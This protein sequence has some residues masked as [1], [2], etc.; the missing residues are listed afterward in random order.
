MTEKIKQFISRSFEISEDDILLS[1]FH[2]GNDNPGSKVLFLASY[3]GRLLCIVKIIRDSFFN[4]KLKKEKEAQE[5]FGKA[6]DM[7]SVQVCFESYI[8]GRYCYAE[9]VAPGK[10]LSARSACKL[11]KEIIKKISAFPVTGEVSTNDLTRIFFDSVPSGD[12]EG[13]S[14]IKQL[15]NK[16]V[17]LKKGFSH[18]DFTRKNVLEKNGSFFLID[19]DRAGDRPFW[20]IDAIHF[21]SGLRNINSFEDYKRD[22]LPLFVEYTGVDIDIA[23]ALCCIEAIF[24]ILCKKYPK[25]Y[26]DA[27]KKIALL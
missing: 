25:N 8:D 14:L 1:K 26:Q 22:I 19:W 7:S 20:M 11:E 17:F 2:H 5:K 13:A 18:G 3:C 16:T 6:G 24:E 27:V 9:G 15:G 4:D 21:M 12:A 10:P 23:K